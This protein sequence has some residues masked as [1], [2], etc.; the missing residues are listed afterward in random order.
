MDREYLESSS[1]SREERRLKPEQRKNLPP[2]LLL[3]SII[4]LLL[5]AR[6]SEK[7]GRPLAVFVFLRYCNRKSE[8]TFVSFLTSLSFHAF[9]NTPH[10][11]P[12]FSKARSLKYIPTSMLD[13]DKSLYQVVIADFFKVLSSLFWNPQ[14]RQDVL[15]R[16]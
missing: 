11:L 7:E 2:F 14:S 3:I 13:T 12:P 4:F 8:V 1:R 10:G 15:D 16:F 9:L 5:A 6:G